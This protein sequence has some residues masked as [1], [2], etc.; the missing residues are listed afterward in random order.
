MWV[1]LSAEVCSRTR[2]VNTSSCVCEW[3]DDLATCHLFDLVRPTRSSSGENKQGPV[4][5]WE[6]RVTPQSLASLWS[7]LFHL[8]PDTGSKTSVCSDRTQGRHFGHSEQL[9]AIKTFSVLG[10][11]ENSQL[12]DT[13]EWMLFTPAVAWLKPFT[14]MPK[15]TIS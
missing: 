5:A 3:L 1:A 9:D 14:N 7:S 15:K 10:N 6:G 4:P 8:L 11:V 13:A 12:L 2:C